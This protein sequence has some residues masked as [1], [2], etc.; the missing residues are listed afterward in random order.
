MQIF[1]LRFFFFYITP[2]GD[3]MK[4]EE[5]SLNLWKEK[6]IESSNFLS[7]SINGDLFMGIAGRISQPMPKKQGKEGHKTD[8]LREERNT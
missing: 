3:R 4:A 6:H 7:H 1:Y 5:M 2:H 8:S